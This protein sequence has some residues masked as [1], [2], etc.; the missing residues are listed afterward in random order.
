MDGNTRLCTATAA[1]ALKESFGSDGQPG[2]YEDVDACDAIF[3]YGHNMPETQTVL[4]ARVLD[5][6]VAAL[7]RAFPAADE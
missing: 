5:A 1:A 3:L 4:W 6:A 7:L 2:S